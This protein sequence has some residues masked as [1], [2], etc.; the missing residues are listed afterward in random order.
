MYPALWHVTSRQWKSHRLRVALTTLGIALGVAVFFAVRTANASLLDSLTLTVERLAGKSTLEVTAG[1]SGFSEKV[2]ETVRST[3]GV[4]V[5]EPV[6]EVM[7]HTGFEDEGNLL[8][9]GV[10]ATGDQSLREYQFARSQ[11]E[12]SDPLVYIAQPNSIL[13]SRA[14]ADR[15]GLRIGDPLPLF[16]SHG[17]K[18]FTVQGF[19]KPVGI[20]EIF[21]GNIAVMDVYS[22]QV[23]FDRGRNFDRIDLLNSPGTPVASLQAELRKRLPAGLDVVRPEVRGQALENAVTAMRLAMLIASFIALLVGVFI[24]FNSFTIAVNQRWKEI[25]ILRAIGVERKYIA[26]MFLGEALVMAAIGSIIGIWAGYYLAAIAN[27]VMG[28][29]AASIYGVVSTSEP[30]KFYLNLAVVSF[31]LGIASSLG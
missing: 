7:A 18:D 24:I 12:I 5:A 23:E 9:M 28:S 27:K 16:T 19:F 29:I 13:V 15:H 14:F 1:E 10:D 22:A 21:G 20:G 3:P 8:I 17:R 11:S 2:L 26:G 25:G 31:L 6:I 30:S 4:Q